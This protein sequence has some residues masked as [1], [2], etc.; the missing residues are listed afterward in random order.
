MTERVSVNF[1]RAAEYY[2]ATRGSTTEHDRETTVMLAGELRE[3]GRIL[4]VGVGTGQVHTVEPGRA[5][6][7]ASTRPRCWPSSSTSP[8]ASPRPLVR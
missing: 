2:D 5:P 1:D 7:R 6:W 8:M 4:E 3:R